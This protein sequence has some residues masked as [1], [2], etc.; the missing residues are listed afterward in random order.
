MQV[1]WTAGGN[2]AA[3]AANLSMALSLLGSV[4]VADSFNSMTFH[5]DGNITAEYWESDS[6]DE[7]GFQMPDVQTLLKALIGPDGS[8]ISMLPR[9]P[10]GF[11]FRR[12]IWLSGMRRT[13]SIWF[14]TWLLLQVTMKMPIS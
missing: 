5:E 6:D 10:I 2:Y 11:L 12:P 13:I 14:L 8:I 4:N 1:T 7:G 3:S 9:T